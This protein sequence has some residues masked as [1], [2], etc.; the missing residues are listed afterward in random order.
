MNNKPFCLKGSKAIAA[1]TGINHN[2]FSY[3]V[4]KRGLPAWQFDGKG[5]YIA[6]VSDLEKWLETMRKKNLSSSF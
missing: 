2:N 1:F 6:L 3:F 4:T 5:H